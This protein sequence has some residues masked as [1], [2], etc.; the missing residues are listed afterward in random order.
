M[1]FDQ[2]LNQENDISQSLN[3]GLDHLGAEEDTFAV[4]PQASTAIAAASISPKSNLNKDGAGWYVVYTMGN[5]EKVRQQILKR[6]E[7]MAASE[8]ISEV[9]VPKKTVTKVKAGKR[10]EQNVPRYQRYIFVNMIMNDTTFRVVRHTPGVLDVI[11]RPLSHVEVARL[12]GRIRK[13][14]I[15]KPTEEGGVAARYKVEFE[16]GDEVCVEGGAF[17]GFTGKASSIDLDH[18]KVTVTLS[19]FGRFTPVEL[20]IDQVHPVSD[21]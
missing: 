13:R 2:N 11:D 16:V 21:A 3:E 4:P 9:F 1:L 6:A 10:V 18:G 19:V 5:E 12:F 20:T 14:F 7:N 17:D 15:E 8:F